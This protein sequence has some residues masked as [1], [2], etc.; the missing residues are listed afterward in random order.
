MSRNEAEGH[1]MYYPS[2]RIDQREEYMAAFQRD[3]FVVI[4]DV[5]NEEECEA[6]CAEAWDTIEALSN[7]EGIG[8]RLLH[9]FSSTKPTCVCAQC[10]VR[11]HPVGMT[12]NGQSKYAETVDLLDVF[13]FGSECQISLQPVSTL[14]YNR[15][16]IV[17][18][19]LRIKC[20]LI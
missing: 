5:L 19:R 14:R 4:R 11:T 10:L 9:P 16:R 6:A 18:T 3:G 2:F 20:F 15:G 12:T 7:H 13:P 17:K 1:E 8:N